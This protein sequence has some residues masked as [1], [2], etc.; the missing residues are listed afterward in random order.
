MA[1]FKGTLVQTYGIMD[2]KLHGMLHCHGLSWT[3]MALTGHWHGLSHYN[4]L[5][6]WYPMALLPLHCHHG[7]IMALPWKTMTI[8]GR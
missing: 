6:S 5:S 4:V 7:S 3:Y 2:A 1:R 8:H